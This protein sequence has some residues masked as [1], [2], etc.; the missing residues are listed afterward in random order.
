MNG[1]KFYS[2]GSWFGA[3]V[4]H[5]ELLPSKRKFHAFPPF[6]RTELVEGKSQDLQRIASEAI[7]DIE[8]PVWQLAK[9]D[10]VG[11]ESLRKTFCALPISKDYMGYLTSQVHTWF[12]S[13]KDVDELEYLS[14]DYA[15][16]NFPYISEGTPSDQQ[17]PKKRSLLGQAFNLL[18]M[19]ITGTLRALKWTVGKQ[20]RFYCHVGQIYVLSESDRPF[21]EIPSISDLLR[22]KEPVRDSGEVG[23]V[24]IRPR[25]AGSDQLTQ[26]T[27]HDIYTTDNTFLVS[28][29]KE[30]IKVGS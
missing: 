8:Q 5:P 3:N 2:E 19:P 12:S 10:S 4:A 28:Q 16:A 22:S 25:L 26:A 23:N 1:L 7:S 9:H 30:C 11:K 17:L 15:S 18:A 13:K 24:D 20:Q 29:T 21:Q 27:E 14:V 6:F